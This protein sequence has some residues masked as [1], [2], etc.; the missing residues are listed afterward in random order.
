MSVSI[1]DRPR[2]QVKDEVIEVLIYNFSRSVISDEAFERRLDAV[3]NAVDNEAMLAQIKDLQTP[4]DDSI[5]K[6]QE[7]NFNVQYT[8]EPAK[9]RDTMVSVLGENDRSGTWHVPREIRL[10]TLLG[11]NKID[12]THARFSGPNVTVKVL[13]LLGGDEIYVPENIT[14]LSKAF[15]LLGSVSNKAPS[16]AS[17]QAPTVTIEGVV[18][19]GELVVKV[20]KTM[21]EQFVAIANQMKTMFGD[22]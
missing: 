3:M 4:P 19:L 6:Q 1:N 9:Q 13:C 18:I 17:S 7:Q 20:K 22:I 5:K 8:N 12:F 16:I 10:F 15:C 14:I 11:T 21:K 2:D